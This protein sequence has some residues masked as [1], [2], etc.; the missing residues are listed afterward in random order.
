MPNSEQSASAQKFELDNYGNQEKWVPVVTVCR[1]LRL[2]LGERPSD[3]EGSCEYIE[4][5]VA[6]SQEGVV[7]QLGGLGDVLTTYHRKSLRCHETLQRG[8]RL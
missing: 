2:L 3:V 5:A 1:V 4:K 6:D 8:F 7:L